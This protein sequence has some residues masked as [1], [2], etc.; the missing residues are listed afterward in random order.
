MTELECAKIDC[1]LSIYD[2]LEPRVIKTLHKELNAERIN[3]KEYS[4]ILSQFII[5]LLN[6]AAQYPLTDA[7]AAL[8][9][10]QREE[11]LELI[12]P[13]KEFLTKQTDAEDAKAEL[14]IRQAEAY[15]DNLRVEKAKQYG[16]TLGMVFAGANEVGPEK[17]SELWQLIEAITPTPTTTPDP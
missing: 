13:K 17:W 10:A 15:D 9:E 12:E 3:S 4:T 16:T 1:V 7:Q 5:A 2:K 11:I 8:V 6:I 14:Y